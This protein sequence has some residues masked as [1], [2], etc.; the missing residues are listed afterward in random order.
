MRLCFLISCGTGLDMGENE[1]AIPLHIKF[2]LPG[3]KEHTVPRLH[4][5]FRLPVLAA[6]LP[7]SAD[8][9]HG[10]KGV[11]IHLQ[12]IAPVQEA[13]DTFKI[14]AAAENAERVL[15]F[16][17]G[18]LIIMGDL[19]SGRIHDRQRLIQMEFPEVAEFILSVI[20]I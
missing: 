19:I 12:R 15:P 14:L 4:V 10:A 11:S 8:T 16:F 6:D 17:D 9:N 1:L 2:A 5:Q 20:I 13:A 3:R 18:L 7:F